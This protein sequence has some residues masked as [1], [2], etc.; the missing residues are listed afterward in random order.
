MYREDPFFTLSMGGQVG[1]AALSAVLTLLTVYAA[2][3]PFRKF[4]FDNGCVQLLSRLAV[5]VFLLWSFVWLSPQ[6]YYLYFQMIFS[7]LPWQVVIKEPPGPGS[8][9]GLLLFRGDTTLS[10][11]SKGLLG[12][13][14][15][16]Y[17]FARSARIIT[18]S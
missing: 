6:V 4:Q 14:L 9:A 10:N 7:G 13:M 5:A 17:A 3:S 11:H 1:L 2:A 18:R 15:L 8:I 16:L 12:W